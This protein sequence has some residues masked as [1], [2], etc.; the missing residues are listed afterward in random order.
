MNTPLKK[1][2]IYEL[3]IDE[4]NN[5]D[6][7][8]VVCISLV[9]K[10]AIEKDFLKFAEQPQPVKYA[11]QDEAQQIVS[12]PILIPGILIYRNQPPYGEYYATATKEDIVQIVQK[13]ARTQQA[14]NVNLEHGADGKAPGC[15]LFESFIIDQNRGINAPSSFPTLPDG[16]WFGSMKIDNADVWADVQNGTFNGF[17]I[18]GFF[19]LVP[20][21]QMAADEP[22]DLELC[23][24]VSDF[25]KKIGA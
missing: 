23:Q 1:L 24:L 11:V 4:D 10:P 5:N 6:E 22:T 9:A 21:T 14:T 13:Y 15:Y 3:T 2:P 16:T 19:D 8:G 17:S 20:K 18:E 25:L 7:T 12:G